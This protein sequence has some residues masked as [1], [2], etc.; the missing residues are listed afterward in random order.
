MENSFRQKAT[1][2]LRKFVYASQ[3]R[4]N[5]EVFTKADI[6]DFIKKISTTK[7]G[8]GTATKSTDN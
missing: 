1:H 8:T 2:L 5:L 4:Y 3:Y 6:E 7:T